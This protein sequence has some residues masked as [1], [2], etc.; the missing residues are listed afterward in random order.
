MI[1]TKITRYQL[2]ALIIKRLMS[3]QTVAKRAESESMRSQELKTTTLPNGLVVTSIENQSPITRIGVIVKAGSR[4]EPINELGLTH[5]LRSMSGFTTKESTVFGIT[6]NI[7]YVGGSLSA[8]TSRDLM[9]YLLENDRN[10]TETTLKYLSDTVMRPAFKPWQIK[11]N[12]YRQKADLALFKD[13]PQLV[14]MEALNSV[15]FR[16][17]LRN[18][19]YSPEFMLG[20][21]SSEML[22]N[23]VEQHFV[24]NRTAI[25]GTGIEHNRL[26]EHID[27][28][29]SMARGDRGQTGESK[30]IGGQTR[31]DSNLDNTYVAVATEGVGY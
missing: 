27:K 28:Y 30:F 8:I 4:Y 20:K 21:H 5:T 25:V 19:I 18:S 24:S 14:L 10:Y 2:N 6:R 16:G 22:S 9:I 26:L 1:T 12:L 29:F 7:E 23:F 3:S 13:N 31:I 15:A 17:G 11:D